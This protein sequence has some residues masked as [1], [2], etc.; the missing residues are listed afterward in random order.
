MGQPEALLFNMGG[1]LGGGMVRDSTGPEAGGFFPNS[2]FTC[3]GAHFRRIM[4]PNPE[5][6]PGTL[7]GRS[8]GHF[9]FTFGL[10]LDGPGVTFGCLM[11]PLGSFGVC[12]ASSGDSFG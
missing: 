11:G 3:I 1:S 5:T 2:C 6:F 7:S 12:L 4:A 10:L 9:W 8:Q